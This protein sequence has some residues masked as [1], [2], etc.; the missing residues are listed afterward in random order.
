MDKEEVSFWNGVHKGLLMAEEAVSD[1][2][3]RDNQ[4]AIQA[5][6]ER[7]SKVE[8]KQT[9]EIVKVLGE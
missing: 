3:G 7:I 1:I 8:A 9:K 4:E 2:K 5:I 6:R